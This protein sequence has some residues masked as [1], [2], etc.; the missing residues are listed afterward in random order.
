MNISAI[1]VTTPSSNTENM[2]NMLNE[3]EG[4]EVFHHDVS[5]GKLIAIQ[6]AESIHEEVHGLK[7]IKKLPGII[8]AEMVHHYF[9]EDKNLYHIDELEKM[10][11]SCGSQPGDS[12][13]P[14]Y[15]NQ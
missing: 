9:G 15:L 5:T 11:T 6:E 7:K 4:V 3:L 14:E 8:L 13:V 10:D 12:C 1:L 2:I